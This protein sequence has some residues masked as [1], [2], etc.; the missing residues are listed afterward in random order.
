MPWLKTVMRVVPESMVRA[1]SAPISNV[2]D[3]QRVSPP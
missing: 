1:L 2:I 3:M